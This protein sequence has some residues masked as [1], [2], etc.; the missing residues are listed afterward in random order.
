M[1]DWLWIPLVIFA[2]ALQTVRN[3]SQKSLTK[4]AGTLAATFVR[5]GYGLPFTAIALVVALH[6]QQAPLPALK[7]AFGAWVLAGGMAQ[8][9]ATALLLAAMEQRSFIVAMA[10]SKTEMLQIALFSALILA[11]WVSANTAVA[12]VLATTGVIMLSLRPDTLRSAALKDWFSSAALFGIGSG[13]LFA[14]S[15]VCFRGAILELGASSPWLGGI[16]TLLW[17][18]IVQS[19]VLGAYLLWRDRRGLLQVALS[20]RVSLLAG[21]AGA[22]S[23]IGWFIAFGMRNVAD[24]RTLGMVEMLFIFAASRMFFNERTSAREALGMLVLVAGLILICLQL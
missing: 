5:F 1:T 13:A 2:A 7:G 10:Y 14:I 4:V 15:A 17:T 18:Q 19:L 16:Y 9:L 22:L 6:A 21:L 23:S 20:W 11:E 3:A 8:L 12:M 24:V